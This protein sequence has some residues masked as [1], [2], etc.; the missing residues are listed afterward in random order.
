[1]KRFDKVCAVAL[2]VATVMSMAG[3]AVKPQETS[4][5]TSE[6]V[7]T[8]AVTETSASAVETTAETSETGATE[9]T[10]M[11]DNTETAAGVD[12][13]YVRTMDDVTAEMMSCDYWIENGRAGGFDM[14]KVLLNADQISEFNRVNHAPFEDADGNT[15][16]YADEIGA[17]FDGDILRL[18]LNSCRDAVPEKPEEYFLNGRPT[19]AAYWNGLTALDNLAAVPDSIQVRYGYTVKRATLR[20]FPTDDQ[21]YE[22]AEDRYFDYILFSECMPYMPVRIL[23][24]STDGKFLY[25]VFDSF[26]AWVNKECIALCHDRAEWNERQER[27]K[28][29]G[30]TVTAREIRLGDD[31][32]SPATSGQV[33]PMGTHMELV[34][35]SSAPASAGGRTT[36][37]DYVVKVPTRGADGY[38]VDEYVLIPC[39]DDVTVGVLP[40]TSANLLRQAFKLLGDRYG[41]GGDL[42]ANDCSG[43]LREIYNCF[44][45]LLP[46]TKQTS[47]GGDFVDKIDM[48]SMGG[49]AKLAVLHDVMP[50]SYISMPGHMMFYLGTVDGRPYI[51]SAV[52]TFVQ[53]SP[54]SEEILKPRSVVLS[55]LLVR[56]RA[57]KTWLQNSKFVVTIK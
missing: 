40:Y 1:M 51:I 29:S 2:C 3:C 55:S 31:P 43:I 50:G 46:R 25:V 41:W 11:T 18:L 54:G 21:V 42:R 4:E 32:Y 5:E 14:D 47:V 24:E 48:S 22:T 23:H 15:L 19:T 38:A 34:P 8:S 20:L 6:T 57:L 36:F 9:A 17:T 13:T 30:L 49:S 16:F 52:G 26:A 45:I 39:S 7:E 53:P 37:G 28:A 10:D 27:V 44:G 35:S 56:N 33:L 12:G